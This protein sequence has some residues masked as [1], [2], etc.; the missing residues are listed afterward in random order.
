MATVLQQTRLS[1]L[2]ELPCKY[3]VLLHLDVQGLVVGSE[4]PRRLA[5]VPLGPLEDLADRMLFGIRRGRLGDLLQRG[6][7]G[8]R[9]CALPGRRRRVD[10]EEREVF[11]LNHIRREEDGPANDVA[12][13]AHV[14]WPGVAQ[15]ALRGCF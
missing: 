5:L 4:E 3:A 13:L 14:S 1:K 6:T 15:K 7:V 10:G 8:Y 2:S 11:R 9:L 12:E